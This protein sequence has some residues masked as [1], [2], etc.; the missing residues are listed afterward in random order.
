MLAGSGAQFPDLVH[1]LSI[2]PAG[3]YVHDIRKIAVLRANT[4]GD[5]IYAL[6]ALEALRMT[7]PDGEIV[8]LGREWH[9]D[10]LHNRPGPV[11]RVIVV[12]PMHGIYGTAETIE[13]QTQ[14]EHFIT[15]MTQEHFDLAIQ[16]HGDGRYSNPFIMRLGARMTIGSRLP[17]A[18][19]LDLWV[20]FTDTQSEI[21]R[22][23]EVVSLVGAKPVALEPHLHIIE[24][25]IEEVKP[26]LYHDGRPMVVLN[27]GS[28]NPRE[29]WS[30]DKFAAIGDA[31]AAVGAHIFII[32]NRRDQVVA[33]NVMRIMSAKADYLCDRLSLGGLIGLLSQS[34]LMISNNTDFLRLGWA[35]GTATIG[36][37][38]FGNLLTHGPLVRSRHR[39]AVSWRTAC[40]ICGLDSNRLT[41]EHTSSYVDDVTVHEVLSSAL[42]LLT[43]DHLRK[44]L[45]IDKKGD[46]K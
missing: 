26:F 40:P 35:A 39:T 32:G 38:W 19:P 5:F 12:P 15:N 29:R 28:D 45:L 7:F 18:Q 33:K 2:K 9:A 30:A 8:L 42:D 23:L 3:K 6:P 27:P 22:Q 17:E 13:D 21:L 1:R 37:Y 11:D 46:I 44:P 41:C 4:V 25:D 20:P 31:L 34:S 14:V 36:I 10:F 43:T 16:V 24:E